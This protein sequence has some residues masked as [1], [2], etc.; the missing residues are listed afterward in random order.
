MRL[1]R[2]SKILIMICC[3]AFLSFLSITSVLGSEKEN[4]ISFGEYEEYGSIY[5]AEYDPEHGNTSKWLTIKPGEN[6]IRIINDDNAD[7][8]MVDKFGGV[9][10]NGQLYINGKEH[11]QSSSGGFSPKNGFLYFLIIVSLCF[12]MYLYQKIKKL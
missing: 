8:F 10:I 11:T 9:Y 5:G 3:V 6:G 12:N 1:K 4:T 7:I 2:Y